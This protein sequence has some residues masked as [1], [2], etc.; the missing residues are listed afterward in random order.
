MDFWVDIAFAVLLR[1][2][3]SQTSRATMRSAFV[4]LINAIAVAYANDPL[5]WERAVVKPDTTGL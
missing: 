2:V 4:K 5:F 1:A 3:K